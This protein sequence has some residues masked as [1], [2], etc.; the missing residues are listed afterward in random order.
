MKKLEFSKE[1]AAFLY[2]ILSMVDVDELYGAHRIAFTD[3]FSDVD[4]FLQSCKPIPDPKDQ[5]RKDILDAVKKSAR[6]LDIDEDEVEVYEEND[7]QY[8]VGFDYKGYIAVSIELGFQNGVETA[9]SASYQDLEFPTDGYEEADTIEEAI[10]V[11][12]GWCEYA[13]ENHD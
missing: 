3:I 9:F 11:M 5:V 8:S 12:E 6:E 10:S 7:E 1:E 2:D 4:T 13:N